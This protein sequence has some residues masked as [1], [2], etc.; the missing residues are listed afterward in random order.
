MVSPVSVEQEKM[1]REPRL[2]KSS[3]DTIVKTAG[4]GTIYITIAK[5]YFIVAGYGTYFTL[6]QIISPEQFGNYGIVTGIV[7]IINAVI[8]GGTQQAVSK[9]ISE[10]PRSAE[11][12]KRQALWLQ[13]LVGG[14]ATVGYLLAA[15]L[16]ANLLNDPKL[17]TPLRWSALITL[18]YSFYSVYMGYLNGQ[19]KFLWQAALDI[20]Y[21][22]IKLVCIVTL[23]LVLGTVV[24][25]IAGFGLAAL[26]ILCL[27]SLLTGRA[28]NQIN[29]APKA[30]AF[31]KFQF[32]LLGFTLVNNL[33]QKVDLILIK[34]LASPN[35]S[36]ASEL[37]GYYTA[38]M[39]IA[40][41]TYQA[42]I[43]IAFVIF[44]LISNATFEQRTEEVKTYIHQT[45]KY[46]LIVMALSATI[47]SAN[48]AALLGY[49]YRR[50]VYMTGAS[51]LSIVAYGML[52]FGLIHIFTAIISGSGRP[53]I[54]LAIGLGTLLVSIA[55]NS[56]LVPHYGLIGAATSTSIAMAL[57]AGT[58][59]FYIFRT[60]G[61]CINLRSLICIVV[62]AIAARQITLILPVDLISKMIAQIAIYL[63]ILL[64]TREIG[65]KEIES[66]RK[67][68]AI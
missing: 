29:S 56:L 53:R 14:G 24:G 17:A 16:I 51:A 30:S 41:V 44:P 2:E 13:C 49:L 12:V 27:A 21:S 9:F 33:L 36:L 20:S 54:S 60:F 62:A 65:R 68:I 8:L 46:S 55:M 43:S 1:S 26:M 59:G 48:A 38:L 5:L 7:A 57:G 67:I 50:T 6:P 37:A 39:A 10:N 40:N 28:E 23:A 31:I 63:A 18:A 11:S 47:F 34:A 61:A 25:A 4:R 66:I 45:V 19:R 52:C 15:P 64:L 22:T 32:T 3:E 35:S 58:A 42:I